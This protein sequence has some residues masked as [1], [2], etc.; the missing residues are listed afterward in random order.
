MENISRRNFMKGVGAMAVA[1]AATGLLGGC[2][3]GSL[4]ADATGLDETA[5]LKGVK[6]TVR[7]VLYGTDMSTGTIYILP[8]VVIQ[9]SGAGG[10][11]V[12]PANGSFKVIVNGNQ[13][14]VLNA[15]TMAELKTMS[16]ITK[17]TLNRGMSRSGYLCSKGTNIGTPK[18]VYVVFYPN[19]A[20]S[21]TALR[22]KILRN[23]W[24]ITGT[25]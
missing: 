15:N 23:Q 11:P 6:M 22:C 13:E 17:D 10:I 1:T 3:D 19:P 12:D 18:Y 14:M 21:K 4:I 20:D 8:K 25:L 7:E 5:N 2:S 16:P 9:N 24:G